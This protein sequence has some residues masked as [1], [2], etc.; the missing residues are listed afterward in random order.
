MIIKVDPLKD[1]STKQFCPNHKMLKKIAWVL[2]IIGGLNWGF[3]GLFNYDVIA[4]VF[5]A[6]SIITKLIYD[7]VGLSA[8]YLAFNK[9]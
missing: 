4:H 8:L 3:V 7:L 6:G 9:R 1:R 2:L 5:S